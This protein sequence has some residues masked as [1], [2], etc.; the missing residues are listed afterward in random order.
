LPPGVYDLEVQAQID[1]VS[2]PD[3][4]PEIPTLRVTLSGKSG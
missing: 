2:T 3:C 1:G 4:V